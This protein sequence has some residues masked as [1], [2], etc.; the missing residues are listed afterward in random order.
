MGDEHYQ[1]A[2]R[3]K[4]ILQTYKDLQDRTDELDNTK[5]IIIYCSNFDCGL[6]KNAVLLIL[7][8]GFKNVVALEGGI[9]SWQDKG[10]PVE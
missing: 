4:E 7:K 8:A 2:K 5:E 10:Y 1:T 3:V 9:E 6:S